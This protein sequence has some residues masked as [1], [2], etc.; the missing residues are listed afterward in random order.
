MITYIALNRFIAYQYYEY[1]NYFQKK[2]TTILV[3]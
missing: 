1:L 3:I 2:P